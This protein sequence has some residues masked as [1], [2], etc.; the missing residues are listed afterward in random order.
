MTVLNSKMCRIRVRKYVIQYILYHCLI[1]CSQDWYSF[2]LRQEL[3]EEWINKFLKAC[4]NTNGREV[5]LLTNLDILWNSTASSRT[6]SDQM[7][8]VW[9]P[10][11]PES[12]DLGHLHPELLLGDI[13]PTSNKINDLNLN[14]QL[15]QTV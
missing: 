13:S 8:S 3:F 7:K 11:S 14:I 1:T 6:L 4:H 15:M 9:S 12:K 10:T 2:I 5:I